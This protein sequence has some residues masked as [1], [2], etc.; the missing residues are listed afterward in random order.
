MRTL[1]A[2]AAAL[3][4]LAGCVNLHVHFPS[5]PPERGAEEGKAQ[6]AAAKEKK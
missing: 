4:L 2:A 3:A 1:L 6:E 5:A